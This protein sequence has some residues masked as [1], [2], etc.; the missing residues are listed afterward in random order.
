MPPG[1]VKTVSKADRPPVLPADPAALRA[2][3]LR[4]T[5]AAGP[6]PPA[7]E[8]QEAPCSSAVRSGAFVQPGVLASTHAAR[9]RLSLL[10][11]TIVR[12]STALKSEYYNASAVAGMG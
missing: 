11:A 7:G 6:G 4:R 1:G 12:T 9:G 10:C 3:T 8:D 5:L 2:S